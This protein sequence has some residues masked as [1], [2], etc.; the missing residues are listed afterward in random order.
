MKLLAED[1]QIQLETRLSPQVKVQGD[2]YRLKQVLL[3]LIDNAIKYRPAG[4]RIQIR[5]APADSGPCSK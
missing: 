2:R 3:N 1:K 5:L 4:T